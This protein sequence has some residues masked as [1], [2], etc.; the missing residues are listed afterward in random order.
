[1]GVNLNKKYFNSFKSN[2]IGLISESSDDLKI[3]VND[4]NIGK[5]D[6]K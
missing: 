6:K 4:L 2:D 5:D 1:M 3:M